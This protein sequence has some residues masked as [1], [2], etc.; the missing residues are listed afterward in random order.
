MYPGMILNI[1]NIQPFICLD[2][3][4]GSKAYGLDTPAR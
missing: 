1:D 3:I 4:A 2:C